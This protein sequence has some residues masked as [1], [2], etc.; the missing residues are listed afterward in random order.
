MRKRRVLV[1]HVLHHVI[2]ISLGEVNKRFCQSTAVRKSGRWLLSPAA[3]VWHGPTCRSE[4]CCGQRTWLYVGLVG[5]D[6]CLL[7]WAVKFVP[8]LSPFT[9]FLKDAAPV[10]ECCRK[11]VE[12]RAL[13]ILS[14]YLMCITECGIGL[15]AQ[16]FRTRWWYTN[17][18]FSYSVLYFKHRP[19][20]VVC[21]HPISF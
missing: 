17:V 1:L 7:S 18:A 14:S 2:A 9:M 4:W 12:V 6:W 3:Q 21:V 16:D 5:F 13:V 8:I 10:C 15:Y 20:F 11:R 19:Q